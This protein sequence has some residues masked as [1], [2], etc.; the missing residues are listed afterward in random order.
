MTL[1]TAC[2]RA[3]SAALACTGVLAA[4][5]AQSPTEDAAALRMCEE[6]RPEVCTREYRPVCAVLYDETWITA[7]T[8]CTACAREDVKG[9]L[10]GA[11]GDSEH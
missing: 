6:P 7:S 4:C 11:C 5:T 10:S 2:G 3:F 8:G 1:S 9:Y